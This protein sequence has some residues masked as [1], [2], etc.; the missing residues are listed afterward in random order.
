M[1]IN[2]GGVGWSV[3]CLLLLL[4]RMQLVILLMIHNGTAHSRQ[5]REKMKY[6]EK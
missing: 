6:R 4:F 1:M 3:G 2:A 5:A